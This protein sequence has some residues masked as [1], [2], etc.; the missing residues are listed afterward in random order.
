MFQRFQNG[1]GSTGLG[2]SITSWVAQAHGGTLD[3]D[4][5]PLG[6]ARFTLRFP[7]RAKSAGSGTWRPTSS[8]KPPGCGTALA[9]LVDPCARRL[10]VGVFVQSGARVGG[11]DE[12]GVTADP[13]GSSDADPA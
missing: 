2:L 5:G 11:R 13:P 10:R 6:G 9:P 1:F 7:P 4:T 3:I 8:L 12:H